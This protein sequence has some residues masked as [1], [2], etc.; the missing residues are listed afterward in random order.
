GWA[1]KDNE[2]I[3]E[4]DPVKRMTEQVKQLLETMF[5][6]GTANPCQKMTAQQMHEELMIRVRN[7]ELEQ[8]DM[9]K[10]TSIQNWISGFS[11]RWKEAMALRSLEEK[12]T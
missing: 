7:S 12:D 10:I 5:H 9:P 3:H 6:T 8:V 1:L 11:R 4:R 2:K